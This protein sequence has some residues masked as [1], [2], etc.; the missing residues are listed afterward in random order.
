MSKFQ[1]I[2]AD[3]PWSFSDSLKMTEVKRGADANYDTL[4]LQD[5]KDLPINQIADPN[6]C[7][8]ASW[9]PS[10]MLKEGIEVLEAWGFALKQ[11][12]IWVKNK[13]EPFK[14]SNQVMDMN[15]MLAFGMGRIFRGCHE[16]CLI[17]I[18][19]TAIY[20]QIQ[21]RSQRSVCFAE[22]KG[23]SIKP[24]I[25]QDRL[26]KMLPG[27]NIKRIE[28]FARRPREKWTTLGNQVGD[29]EDIRVSL[30]KL[31]KKKDRE[32]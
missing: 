4:S 6:G 10:S 26:E 28:I 18:N 32:A 9:T 2:V 23:H 27:N 29:R 15:N 21:D 11:S 30:G 14:K 20:K 5:I 24:E 16:V 13:K 22:N 25:L 12:F 31:I 7:I 17:G 1:V 3:N 8:L 19:N